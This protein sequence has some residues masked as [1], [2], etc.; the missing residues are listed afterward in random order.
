MKY[1][2]AIPLLF[3][4]AFLSACS[5]IAQSMPANTVEN[6]LYAEYFYDNL[7]EQIV[8]L[9]IQKDPG[10]EGSAGTDAE[11]MKADALAKTQEVK[12]RQLRGKTGTFLPIKEEAVGKVLIETDAAWTGPEFFVTPGIELHLYLSTALDP[13]D[14]PFPG[15]DDL[16][17]GI[18]SPFGAQKLS[19]PAGRTG[20]WRTAVLWDAKLHRLHGF[21]QLQQAV[22]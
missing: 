22:R 12:Q 16:D 21:A 14:V 19:V 2:F 13:R 3:G 1:R 7:I 10:L 11:K 9:Q 6:P 17:L 18:A 5:P 20:D 4:S 8:D 15:P